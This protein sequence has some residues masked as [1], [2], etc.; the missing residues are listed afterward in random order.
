METIALR[1]KNYRTIE[2]E[3]LR[4]L[5]PKDLVPKLGTSEDMVRIFLRRNYP[6]LH[7]K[8]KQ[9]LISPD[10]AKKIERD[11]RSQVNAREAVKKL[12]IQKELAG[13]M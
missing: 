2:K 10:L 3:L 13:E 12:R 7:Q 8:Y 4:P 6:E 1:T 9:W 5:T 11:Y